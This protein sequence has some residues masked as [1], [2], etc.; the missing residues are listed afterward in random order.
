MKRTRSKKP[1][2][3]IEAILPLTPMQEGML[4]HT[5]LEP[6]AGLYCIQTRYDIAGPLRPERFRDAWQAVV[7]RHQALRSC[8]VWRGRD[9]P[10]QVIR[11]RAAVPFEIVDW[12]PLEEAEFEADFETLLRADRQRG[13]DLTRA[14]LLR[15]TLV[16]RGEE[17]WRLL[18]SSHHLITDGWSSPLV[19]RDVFQAYEAGAHTLAPA[20]AYRDYIQWLAKQDPGRAES[21]WR[22]SLAGFTEPVSMSASAWRWS[23]GTE[24][25]PAVSGDH[26]LDLTPAESRS[27]AELAANCQVTQNTCVQLAWALL[28][29]RRGGSGTSGPVRDVVF[30]ATVSGRPVDLSGVDSM[31]GLFI[32][33]LPVRV[34]FAAEESVVDLL[35]RLQGQQAEARDYE[36]APLVRVQGWSE[37]PRGQQLFDSLVVF[38]SFPSSRRAEGASGTRLRLEAT[39]SSVFSNYPLALLAIPRDNHLRLRL[40][41]DL[42]R[43]DRAQAVVVLEQL[44]HLLLQMAASP[45]APVGSLDLRPEAHGDR[46]ADPSAP[47]AIETVPTV[48]RQVAE[49]AELR[50][51]APAVEQGATLLDRSLLEMRSA[52]VARRLTELGLSRGEVVAVTGPRCPAWIVAMLAVWRAGGVLLT[53]DPALPATRRQRMVGLSATRFALWITEGIGAETDPPPGLEEL[54]FGRLDFEGVWLGV[55]ARA[56]EPP[57]GERHP[58][59]AAYLFFTSGTTGEPKAVLGSHRGLA[60]FLRWQRQRFDLAPGDRAAQLTGWSFDVVLRDCFAPLVSGGTLCMPEPGTDT[61]RP[62]LLLPWL[63]SARITL[64]HTVPSVARAWL[65]GID[66]ASDGPRLDALRWI[67]FA[68]EPLPDTVVRQV[69]RRL[70]PAA[71]IANLY[72]PTETTLAKCCAVLAPDEEPQ[73]GI[74]AVGRPLPGAQVLVLRRDVGDLRLAGLE[75]IG[76]VALRTPYRSHGYLD[77]AATRERFLVNP[78]RQD[79]EDRLYRSGDLG[80]LRS[81]GILELLGRVD[82]Q[83]KVRGVRVEPAEVAAVLGTESTV[84]SVFVAGRPRSAAGAGDIEL[85][86]WVE[87]AAGSPLDSR[88]L[89]SHVAGRLPASHVPTVWVAVESMPLTANGKIDR[90]ALPEPAPVLDEDHHVAP[91]DGTEEVVAGIWA[92]VL[93]KARIGVRDDF[94]DLGGHSLVATQILARLRGALEVDLP[95][96]TLFDH[97]TVEGL[98][99]VVDQQRRGGGDGAWPELVPVERR[100]GDLPLSASQLRLWFL[101]QLDPGST[102]YVIPLAVEIEGRFETE[103]LVRV[104]EALVERHEVLRTV[105]ERSPDAEEPRQVIL[106]PRPLD[107]RCV[108]LSG[109]EPERRLESAAAI[110]SE[111]AATPFDLARGP[112]LRATLV[113]LAPPGEAGRHLLLLT[114]HHIISDGWSRSVLVRDVAALY[115]AEEGALAPPPLPLQYADYAVWQ[116]RFFA[117]GALEQQLDWW[118]SRLADPPPPLELPTDRQRPGHRSYPGSRVH[119]PLAP[120]ATERLR[121]FARQRSATPH[122]VLLAVFAVLLERLSGSREV[123]IGTPVAGRSRPELEDLIGFFINTLVMRVD[124]SHRQS[125]GELLAS[126]REGTLEVYAHQDVPFERVVEMLQPERRLDRT[127]LFQVMLV[128]HAPPRAELDLPGLRWRLREQALETTKFDLTLIATDQPDSLGLTF[129][130]DTELFD[131]ATLER[132]AGLFETLLEA[133]VAAPDTVL[134]DLPWLTPEGRRQLLESARGKIFD[135]PFEAPHQAIARLA[136]EASD[137]PALAEGAITVS[138]GELRQQ[139]LGFASTLARHGVGAGDRVALLL[140]RSIDAVVTALATLELGAA[141]V[142]IDPGYPEE[143]VTFILQDARPTVVVVARGSEAARIAAELPLPSLSVRDPEPM[144]RAADG[145]TSPGVMAPPVDP[146]LPAYLIYTSGS[147]GR[148]KGVVIAHG[149]LHQYLHGTTELLGLEPGQS[150]GLVQTLAFDS[151][152]TAVYPPLV[153]GGTLSIF[154]RDTATDPRRLAAALAERPVD[155]LKISPSHLAALLHTDDAASVLPRRWLVVGGEALPA[156]VLR[157]VTEAAP[158][159]R[160]VN[161]Y[162]PTETTVGIVTECLEIVGEPGPGWRPPIGRPLPGSVAI[163]LDPLGRPVP[164]GVPGEL[165]LGGG[166]VAQGYFARPG[167]TARQFV[168]NPFPELALGPGARLYR[169]GDLV[170]WLEDGRLD[171]L[172]RRDGQIKVRGHRVELGEIE[173]CLLEL[174]VVAEAAVAPV[175]VAGETR[176]VAY[177]VAAVPGPSRQ[178][179]PALE[180]AAVSEWLARRLPTPMVPARLIELPT[181]PKNRHGKLDR[182]ALPDPRID[183][184]WETV[185]G[186]PKSATESVLA[187]LW[188]ALLGVAHVGRGDDFFGLGGH[189]L[190]ATR[191]AGRVQRR[192]GFELPVRTIFEAPVLANLA[193]RLDTLAARGPEAVAPIERLPRPE[194]GPWRAPLSF[195]QER[196]WFLDQ[197]EPGSPAYNLAG[198]VRLVGALDVAAFEAAVSALVAH[199]EILRTTFPVEDGRPVQRIHPAGPC[200]VP[201]IDLTALA[202]AAA[203]S[204]ARQLAVEEALHPFDLGGDVGADE[205]SRG[206]VPGLVRLRLLRLVAS[207]HVLLFTQHHIISDAWSRDLLVRQLGA[208]YAAELAARRDGDPAAA[209]LPPLEVQ[210]A[211]FAAWQRGHGEALLSTQLS[212]WR[213]TLEGMATTLDLPT[214][215]PRPPVLSA[216][217]G[218]VTRELSAAL[219][220]TIEEGAIRGE[221]ESRAT[222]FMTLLAIFQLLLARWSGQTDVAVGTPVSGRQRAETEHLLGFFVN[223]LVVR[224]IVDPRTSFAEL[225]SRV[226]G[227]IL[228]AFAHQD[229]PFERLV[230]ALQPERRLDHTPLFQVMFVVRHADDEDIVL[231][232]LEVRPALEDG[233]LG[234]TTKFDLILFVDLRRGASARLTLQYAADLFDQATLER[235]LDHFEYLAESA[236]AD[237]DRPVA[238]LEMLGPRERA[239]IEGV[240]PPLPERPDS[241]LHAMVRRQAARTPGAVAL[242]G[243]ADDLHFTYDELARTTARWA[244]GLRQLGV[245]PESRVAICVERGPLVVVAI[246]AVLE[247]GGAYVPLD[248]AYP[249]ERLLY[250]LE[251]SR[252]AVLITSSKLWHGPLSELATRLSTPIEVVFGDRPPAAWEEMPTT[253]PAVS[254]DARNLAYCIY[255]SGSTGQPKGVAITHD[256]A[257]ALVA[258][259]VEA[260]APDTLAVVLAATSICFD[261]SV[262]EI[263][264][265]L[266]VGGQ[267]VVVETALDLADLGDTVGVTLVNTVPSVM[268]EVLRM[269]GVPSTVRVVNLA[270]EP[271]PGRLAEGLYAL[272]SVEQVYNLYG[273]SEDTTYSTFVA[274]PRRRDREPTIG[275]PVAGTRVAVLDAQGMPVPI[276]VVGELFLGGAGLCRGYL[277]RPAQTAERFLPDPAAEPGARRYRTGDLVRWLPTGELEFLGR[278]DHQ[279][280]IRGFRIE[281]GEIESHLRQVEGVA[282]V[283]VVADRGPDGMR[284]VAYLAGSAP[285]GSE[286]MIAS[287]ERALRRHLPEHMVPSSWAVLDAL[288]QMPNGKVDRRSLPAVSAAGSARDQPREAP[289]LRTPTEVLVAGVW[290]QALG[291]DHVGADD[292][293]FALGGHSLSAARVVNQLRAVFGR[294]PDELP[295]RLLFEAPTVA[296]LAARLDVGCATFTSEPADLWADVELEATIRPAGPRVDPTAPWRR[297]LLT[298]ATGFVGAH[299]LARLLEQTSAEIHCLLR[300]R[301]PEAA[302]ARLRRSLAERG[303]WRDAYEERLV[304]VV[305]DLAEPRLGLDDGTWRRLAEETDAILHAGAWVQVTYPYSVLRPANVLGTQEVLRLAAAGRAQPVHFVSTLSV[306]FDPA[307]GRGPVFEADSLEHADGPSSGYAQSKWV[308]EKLVQAARRRGM[309]VTVYRFGRVGWHS[310]SGDWNTED[311]LFHALAGCLL[312]G[313]APDLDPVIDLIPVDR[314]TRAIVDLAK[315][316]APDS[317]AYHLLAP[318]TVRWSQ[319]VEWLRV[320]GLELET[321]PYAEWLANLEQRALDTEALMKLATLMPAAAP[322]TPT[323]A[324][325]SEEISDGRFDDTAAAA[326]LAAIDQSFPTTL[327]LEL[328]ETLVGWLRARLDEHRDA[329][330]EP[331]PGESR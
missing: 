27:V 113:H 129:E 62:D 188:S 316:P 24:G 16:R 110:Q 264:V 149:A 201:R 158:G 261:L 9:I 192:L 305:G 167:L 184:A 79:P 181:L 315:R 218:G 331:V 267:V 224:T 146:F 5:R 239:L 78:W 65:G 103:T 94:F 203:T 234:G 306:F 98:A 274:V 321:V 96:R 61:L 171:F 125:F 290:R 205:R 109:E 159:V 253:P 162:G 59:D 194:H 280:K 277:G 176:L 300:A 303:L 232:G 296:R 37:V 44:R 3:N 91:R 304:A 147:T 247:A 327:D 160:V 299:L 322:N 245:G 163:A 25:E 275:R 97:P 323:A 35:L 71:A 42:S 4:F 88:R 206:A 75:E 182:S 212:W 80:R 63:A 87:T 45:G 126:V 145:M 191:L 31:V 53:L 319:L 265:P 104:L 43:W 169:T 223:T 220:R 221:A 81:D 130:Y 293:F 185:G 311:V 99:R 55:S 152:V 39:R 281:L 187:E 193:Q 246:L 128:Y 330:A 226:R 47:L 85:V 248:P 301:D 52:D 6:E 26:S 57:T 263:F 111:E 82:D 278:I 157:Q 251:D 11:E 289:P 240:G 155:L 132:W 211:D 173:A 74:Q 242:Q 92:E 66:E 41:F 273:P 156:A 233:E 22:R 83:L 101:D 72:G 216:R 122:M 200:T 136:R 140:A 270:G 138:R 257:T 308:A 118:R 287:G 229:L 237:P 291:V 34:R 141:Y 199:H 238:L 50:P 107:L 252:A 73:P 105:F 84:R 114:L 64:L 76:E 254:L 124:P 198:A 325:G 49:W 241:T 174:P 137:A 40:K 12:R 288:P 283:A 135:R 131:A 329:M 14:P 210:Y 161:E 208:L 56:A 256:N 29:G 58:E 119:R 298:G 120:E 302:G 328:F 154:D 326:A 228:D 244:H 32:N 310:V 60:H 150:Y 179:A 235:F 133:A 165:F 89:R 320:L 219:T 295:L 166:S 259:A 2:K 317:G 115:A 313:Q 196:L 312:L 276:G 70:A 213:K 204:R 297:L 168:P 284:L 1:A 249:E 225:R 202:P 95:L 318:G 102:A 36:H 279:V 258:W 282:E 21:F 46:L 108:D 30:G 292:D 144:E 178:D 262:Y 189:S 18:W 38:E 10:L 222:P 54:A 23:P 214:D 207:E 294:K 269:D 236:L 86:A 48:V 33:T 255:T 127:P 151:A 266:S 285:E 153:L 250:S 8:F 307:Y 139:V 217:G 143:R 142:P 177:V 20:P 172:G 123:W 17:R 67:F 13:F 314:L 100:D 175:V 90:K 231:P 69:R 268:N 260:F 116:Q 286:A 230:E 183:D 243:G 209:V 134:A 164:A 180:L 272:D 106:P 309:P 186:P 93:G 51:E 15:L 77:P 68:G 19:V 28:L 190:L 215:R 121:G 271:L 170:R 7:D 117:A 195:G 112:L 227:T 324:T 148:P 197:L